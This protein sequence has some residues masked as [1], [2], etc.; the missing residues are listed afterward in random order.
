MQV[1]TKFILNYVFCLTLFYLC[2]RDLFRTLTMYRMKKLL[3]R[4]TPPFLL[5]LYRKC[6]P[7][8]TKFSK[9]PTKEVF[10][11]IYKENHWK[12]SESI[13]GKGSE[14]IQTKVLI[15]ELEKLFRQ[16]NI[17]S[18]L[19]IPC[20]DFKW[21]QKADLTGIHYTG[22]DIVEELIADNNL[23]YSGK[24]NINFTVLDIIR[25]PLPKCDLMHVRDCLVHL[26][27]ADIFSALK[28]IKASGCTYLLT[29]TFTDR[30]ENHDIIT[31]SWRAINLLEKPFSLPK[32]ILI[33]N[34]HCTE[35]NNSFVDKSMALWKI[36][37]I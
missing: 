34:E 5:S 37:D 27:Y 24:S 9:L 6:S 20:G 4:L 26:S 7:S 13:S 17:T 23:K 12:S 28:N 2:H 30:K 1:D 32:P 11:K 10:T 15:T 25:D 19:D 29:T 3:K 18:V 35:D 21:M 14:L 22:A 8:A 31:G 33:I 36:E 16:L